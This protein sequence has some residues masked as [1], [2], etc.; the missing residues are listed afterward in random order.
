MAYAILRHQLLDIKVVVRKSITYFFPTV[1]ISAL[2]F[3]MITIAFRIFHANSTGALIST[4]L[5]VSILAALVLQPFRD[6][7]QNWIDRIFFREQYNAVRMIQRVGEA[8]TSSIDLEQLTQMIL[9]EISQHY[10]LTARLCF[11]SKIA[12]RITSFFIRP[13]CGFHGDDHRRR[14]S[15]DRSTFKARPDFQPAGH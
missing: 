14:S 15:P 3:L 5:V 11:S 6:T 2:Y 10:T 4:S 8:A 12:G 7:L 13:V 9:G 1:I